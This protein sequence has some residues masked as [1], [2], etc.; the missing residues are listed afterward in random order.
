MPRL[1]DPT[2]KENLG[3][4]WTGSIEPAETDFCPQLFCPDHIVPNCEASFD[5]DAAR[6][7]TSYGALSLGD[8]SRVPSGVYWEFKEWITEETLPAT[9]P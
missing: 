2:P 5:R 1:G 6:I 3:A 7:I 4:P 8:M 9:G